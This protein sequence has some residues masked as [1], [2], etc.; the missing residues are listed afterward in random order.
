MGGSFLNMA[1][2]DEDDT[3]GIS[4]EEAQLTA[5]GSA[6]GFLTA[7]DIELIQTV[8]E[9]LKTKLG[10]EARGF[11]GSW[12][13]WFLHTAGVFSGERLS[14]LRDRLVG[15]AQKLDKDGGWGMLKSGDIEE[16][17]VQ[18]RCV[19]FHEMREGGGLYDPTHK[20]DGSLITLDCMLADPE[21][22][23]GGGTFQTLE[24][25]GSMKEH[26]FGQGDV[27][28]FVSHKYH[29]V[30]PVDWGER[31]VMI[32]ELWR[33]ELRTC[34][35]RCEQP[36]GRCVHAGQLVRQAHQCAEAAGMQI[37][38]CPKCSHTF[39]S[40]G[41]GALPP[42]HQAAVL[43][44]LRV[45]TWLD[46]P[47]CD[48]QQVLADVTKLAV[49]ATGDALVL[50]S[51]QRKGCPG[52]GTVV[53][54]AF[55][56]AIKM[57]ETPIEPNPAWRNSEG[58]EKLFLL[59][60]AYCADDG[61]EGDEEITAEAQALQKLRSSTPKLG[62]EKELTDVEQVE[63]KCLE[64]SLPQLKQAMLDASR[65]VKAQE[66]KMR[67]IKG[68]VEAEASCAGAQKRQRTK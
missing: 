43:R 58:F 20:D 35:H 17:R 6:R 28:G 66:Q 22:D 10:H 18:L 29:C 67:I 61:E 36:T 2:R 45:S 40:A 54:A 25:D 33:G 51:L 64:D 52:P 21:E 57:L 11:D 3:A 13:T 48:V 16:G 9:E 24:A 14:G 49:V 7:A 8:A 30:Q 46:D 55:Q 38:A 37:I 56:L 23:F 19:E 68:E 53:L 5:V 44:G 42:E 4:A 1:A 41:S 32:L 50:K 59:A 34:P 12:D 63:L 60:A 27:V 15:L 47:D 31:S 65:A 39:G 26:Q 62:K